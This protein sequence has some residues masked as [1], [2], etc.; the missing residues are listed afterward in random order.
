[1]GDM[2]DADKVVDMDNMDMDAIVDMDC[3]HSK[4]TS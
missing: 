4:H 3:E 2:E 1:M